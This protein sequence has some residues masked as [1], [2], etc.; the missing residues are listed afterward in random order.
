MENLILSSIPLNELTHVIQLTVQREFEKINNSQNPPPPDN[1]LISRK[2][3][4]QI[5]GISLPTLNEYT[6][7][8][9]IPSYRIGSCVRYKKEEVLKSLDERRFTKGHSTKKQVKAL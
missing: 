5:L 4:S 8:G 6:K 1:E 9:I 3:T 7:R 2:E